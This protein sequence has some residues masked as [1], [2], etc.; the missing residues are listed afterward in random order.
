VT[1]RRGNRLPL[2]QLAPYLLDVPDP[3]RPLDFASIFGNANPFEVEVG[4]GKGLFLLT[5]AGA[6]P[7]VNFLGI[8]IDRK[9]Q[10]FTA[11]RLAKR[12]LANVRMVCADARLFMRDCLPLESVQAI[13]VYFPDPW[14]KQRHHKRRLWTP[15]F[16]GECERIL[17][18]AGQLHLATDVEAYFAD[19]TSV[20][21]AQTLL[22]PLPPPESKEPEHDLDYLTNFERKSRK[23]GGPVYRGRYE[24][25][26]D[27]SQQNAP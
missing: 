2:E 5:T 17:R 9:Y 27:P 20:L 16:A 4:S 10:L 3:P 18:P 23:R 22:R 25:V 8:E 14:W 11:T 24:R 1:V 7:D 15:E 12:N 21:A 26:A 13:H 6:R 19:M